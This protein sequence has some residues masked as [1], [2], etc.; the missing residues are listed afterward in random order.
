M[1]LAILALTAC[2]GVAADPV[3]PVD[4]GGHDA[5]ADGPSADDDAAAADAAPVDASTDSPAYLACMNQMGQVDASLKTC[6]ADT[7]CVIVQEQIDCCGTILYLG[8]ASVSSSEYAACEAAWVAHLPACGCSS[9]QTKTEDGKTNYPG[10]D[11]AAPRV[12]C[13][14]FTMSGGVCMTYTP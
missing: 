3:N 1:G 14:D 6:H 9:D 8:I 11:A 13:I 10:M 12:H 7:D 5:Q 4:G 2:G